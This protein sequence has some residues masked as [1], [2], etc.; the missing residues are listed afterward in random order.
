MTSTP[1]CL[2]RGGQGGAHVSEPAGLGERR[3]LG[4]G[5]YHADRGRFGAGTGHQ[6][7]ESGDGGQGRKARMDY[8]LLREVFAHQVF[9]AL[10]LHFLAP[11]TVG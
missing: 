4:R 8:R 1:C 9:V 7:R 2:E 5:E 3:A 6:Q 10:G 11:R